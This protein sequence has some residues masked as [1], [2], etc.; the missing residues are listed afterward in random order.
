VIESHAF[1]HQKSRRRTPEG[2]ILAAI[3]D[4]EVAKELLGTLI[5]EGV[6]RS[7][8]KE[9]RETVE[10]VSNL[11]CDEGVSCQQ[12]SDYVRLHKS[13]I[14]RRVDKAIELGYLV[15]QETR[16]GTPA[17]IIL[18]DPLPEDQVI[19]PDAGQLTERWKRI[20]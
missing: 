13:T 6:Q 14:S 11:G 4:Y 9:V 10:A 5:S 17:K 20:A 7:V 16:S 1:I 18:G 15:N 12:L 3:E 2:E 19:L 8:A